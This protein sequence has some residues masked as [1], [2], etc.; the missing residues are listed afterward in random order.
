MTTS[1]I[2]SLS[3]GDIYTG[4]GSQETPPD[5][6]SLMTRIARYLSG[7]GVVL[8]SGGADGAD[9]AFENGASVSLKEIYLPWKYFN[10]N[11][12]RLCGPYSAQH[13]EM[14]RRFHPAWDRLSQGAQ[15][16]MVRNVAQIFGMDFQKRS[17]L[18]ICWTKDGQASG[19]TGQALR[20]ARAFEIPII[21][22]Y[23][24]NM[25][26]EIEGILRSA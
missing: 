8:R 7:K 20:M 12:S 10:K 25:F 21:N 2:A 4:I 11:T 3:K 13:L 22:L 14:A 5:V 16:L 1:D 19:G 6:M 17:N 15:K 9:T 23:F 26:S 18:V 24:D